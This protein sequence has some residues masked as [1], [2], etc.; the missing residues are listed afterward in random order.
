MRCGIAIARPVCIHVYF[1]TTTTFLLLTLAE[2]MDDLSKRGEH[3]SHPF[4]HATNDL[5]RKEGRPSIRL[6]LLSIPAL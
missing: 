3:M 4:A 1:C 2:W 6:V 5:T